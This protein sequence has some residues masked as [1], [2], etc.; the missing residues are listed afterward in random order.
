MARFAAANGNRRPLP[1][2]L[3][4]WLAKKAGPAS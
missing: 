1:K 3:A 4:D 2:P